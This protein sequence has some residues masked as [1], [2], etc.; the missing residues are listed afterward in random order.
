MYY[1][2]PCHYVGLHEELSTAAAPRGH[3][4]GGAEARD[5]G[6]VLELSATIAPVEVYQQN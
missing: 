1:L 5:R 6:G 2:R 4:G 3:G